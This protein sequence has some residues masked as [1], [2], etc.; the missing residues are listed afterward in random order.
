[1]I[2]QGAGWSP[3]GQPER[4]GAGPCSPGSPNDFTTVDRRID[5]VLAL[6]ELSAH[7]G[8]KVERA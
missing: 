2:V 7:G 8:D 6:S 1:M 5:G 3:G 4:M